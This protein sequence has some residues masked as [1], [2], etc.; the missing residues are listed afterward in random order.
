MSNKVIKSVS[1]NV[2]NEDDAM[3]LKAISRRNFSGY[4]KKLILADIKQKA[5]QKTQQ[6]PTQTATTRELT[7][8]EKLELL[9]S[10][11]IVNGGPYD[12]SNN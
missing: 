4:V 6:E 1:F 3:M 12:I 7:V 10:Q 11:H 2:M 8:K 5:E 9:K